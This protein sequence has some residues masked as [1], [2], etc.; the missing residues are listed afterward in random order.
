MKSDLEKTLLPCPFCGCNVVK[1]GFDSNLRALG[2][3]NDISARC[4]QCGAGT[5]DWDTAERAALDWNK[6]AGVSDAQITALT[7]ERD[8]LRIEVGSY[9]ETIGQLQ[10]LADKGL[11]ISIGG[12]Q[13]IACL[14]DMHALIAEVFH[15][16]NGWRNAT[17]DAHDGDFIHDMNVIL[18]KE[19]RENLIAAAALTITEITARDREAAAKG[20]A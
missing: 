13:Y 4:G 3:L 18:G 8:N 7:A 12:R 9:A 6:R 17:G 14:T 16:I 2:H 5:D 19:T 1:I 15:V 20:G 11:P 10:A